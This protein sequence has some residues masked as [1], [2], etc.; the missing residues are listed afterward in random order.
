[1][2]LENEKALKE[3]RPK[4]F[5]VLNSLKGDEYS[6][7]FDCVNLSQARDGNSMLNITLN[8]EEIRLN[9]AFRPKQEAER[10]V[11]QYKLN[12][13]VNIPLMLGFGNGIFVREILN[14][15][16]KDDVLIIMEPCLQIF[17]SVLDNVNVSDILGDERV[18]IIL[19]EIDALGFEFALEECTN[20]KNIK[21]LCYCEHPEYGRLFPEAYKKLVKTVEDHIYL[22]SVNKSTDVH[23][24]DVRTRTILRNMRHV[25][26]ASILSQCKKAFPKDY[27]AIIVSAGPSLSKNMQMLNEA[28]GKAFIFAVDSAVNS[29]L[30]NNIYFDAMIT[31]DSGK[32]ARRISRDEC[33]EIPLFCTFSS[34]A[35]IMAFHTGKK[36]WVRQEDFVGLIFEEEGAIIEDINLGGCVANAAFA[37][38]VN[39]GFN[40]IVFVG[41]DLAYDGNITHVGGEIKEIMNEQDGIKEIDAALGGKVRSRYDWQ[42]YLDWFET[43]IKQMPNTDVID[44][45]EGGALIH[46]SKVMPLKE[47]ID[48]YCNIEFNMRDFLSKLEPCFGDDKYMEVHKKMSHFKQ[49]IEN[50]SRYAKD[51]VVCCDIV[52]KEIEQI[53]TSPSAYKQAKILTQLN[54]KMGEQRIYGLMDFYVTRDIVDEFEDINKTTGEREEDEKYTYKSAKA[55]YEA[56]SA[57]PEKLAVCIKNTENDLKQ[58]MDKG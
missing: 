16:G 51:A 34:S 13:M 46:G 36:I 32:V 1:M 25:K 17:V 47:T 20:W 58:V 7:K 53:G 31:V 57:I 56:F 14:K 40:R 3:Y 5:G 38:C 28:K 27:P 4:M 29:L 44:S 11:K 8:G 22:V 45:T 33:K 2:L 50:L 41:Q 37:V 48:K 18:Q 55:L 6:K 12:K 19:E 30:D 39:M 10:W 23:F 24:A 52:L 42:I 26:N 49:E 35:A 54:K 15:I 43:V 21:C 9:S